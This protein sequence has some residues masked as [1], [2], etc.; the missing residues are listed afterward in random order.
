MRAYAKLITDGNA[1]PCTSQQED[2]ATLTALRRGADANLLDFH[3]VAVLRAASDFDREAPGQSVAESL[4]AHSGG[5]VPAVTNAYRVGAKVAHS[6]IANWPTW[7][8]GPP[9]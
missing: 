3:R 9:K 7:I 2:N 8:T 6:I 4:T 1:N 5:Y